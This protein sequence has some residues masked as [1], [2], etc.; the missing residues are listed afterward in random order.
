MS[1]P[2]EEALKPQRSLRDGSLKIVAHGEK[3]DATEAA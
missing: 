3:K 2:A 1:A